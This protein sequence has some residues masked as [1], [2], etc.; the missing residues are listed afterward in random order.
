MTQWN[1]VISKV[2]FDDKGLVS[3]IACDKDSSEVL[4]LA[5]MNKESLEITL[6]TGV[7]TYWSR[8]RQKLWKKGETSGNTQKV[9]SVHIDCDGDALMFK[10]EP[11]GI[12]AACHKGYRS[13]F[14][15]RL[16]GSSW[17]IDAERQFDPKEVY[18]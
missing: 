11:Q 5:Y 2:K 9:I 13:C 14:F 8:S 15:S 16:D 17:K 12:G 10:V 3:A 4:M 7:M 18:K 6:N 1:D